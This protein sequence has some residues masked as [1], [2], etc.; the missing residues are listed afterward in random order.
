M[1]RNWRVFGFSL[2]LGQLLCVF[3]LL[4]RA[5]P[6]SDSLCQ[7]QTLSAGAGTCIESLEGQS[8]AVDPKSVFVGE[9]ISLCPPWLP[10]PAEIYLAFENSLGTQG[11]D[12]DSLVRKACTTFVGQVAA[13]SPNTNIDLAS[14]GNNT[15]MTFSGF[16]SMSDAGNVTALQDTAITQP[17][18]TGNRISSVLDTAIHYFGE[19]PITKTNR[20]VVMIISAGLGGPAG[21]KI[22]FN[23]GRVGLL[24]PVHIAYFKSSGTPTD[25]IKKYLGL[26]ADSTG[27]SFRISTSLAELTSVL[28]DSILPVLS[29]GGAYHNATIRNPVLSNQTTSKSGNGTVAPGSSLLRPLIQFPL[30]ALGIGD[31]Q[32]RIS[33]E[34][35]HKGDSVQSVE[36][37]FTLTRKV[38]ALTSGEQTA[39]D[40]VFSRS[41]TRLS[42][43]G[44]ADGADAL[45]ADG[46][47]YTSGVDSAR[48]LVYRQ[49]GTSEVQKDTVVIISLGGDSEAV[50]IMETG[51]ETDVYRGSVRIRYSADT[52]QKG[53]GTLEVRAADTLAATYINT[54]L[55]VAGGAP[56]DGCVDT[57]KV[58]MDQM[59][60]QDPA[61]SITF[62]NTRAFLA[63][64]S[65]R[66]ITWT[67]NDNV[68]I[69]GWEAFLATGSRNVWSSIGNGTG[70]PGEWQWNLPTIEQ[71]ACWIRMV[72]SDPAGNTA[73]DTSDE[74]FS[75]ITKPYFTSP[76]ADTA[77]TTRPYGYKVKWVIPAG[78]SGTIQIDPPSWM[79][80]KTV[81]TAW[82][83]T[84][85]T[86]GATDT[87][88]A[89]ISTTP[90]TY[91]ETLYVRIFIKQYVGIAAAPGQPLPVAMNA[92]MERLPGNALRAI[93]A[94]P[95][96]G[97]FALG[98]Y[99]ICGRAVWHG[100]KANAQAGFHSMRVDLRNG[101]RAGVYFLRLKS[102]ERN[103]VK[104]FIWTP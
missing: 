43:I 73:S 39:F 33:Y 31:N 87:L 28:V 10:V 38:D 72:V 12:P 32:I 45:L 4:V 62:P 92:V 23:S 78:L 89:I 61:V 70:N 59:D 98:V 26:I 25:T 35:V 90:S 7:V 37:N 15:N 86:P 57:I 52:P 69:A 49:P 11:Q 16:L 94:L 79:T 66:K 64:G 30:I 82:G 46:S 60:A 41:C 13:L 103:V 99:D 67:A 21:F 101:L 100:K 58:F 102:Q 8:I 44:F 24:P 97:E 14:Y 75:I 53:S 48:V 83:T 51:A 81:D 17:P 77:L 34:M 93:V 19:L 55:F 6:A 96:D 88:R 47:P 1:K 40:A 68:G 71:E 36:R 5:Q 84:P 54:G 50:E 65:A 9:D 2:I 3:P 22:W 29:P 42:A 74:P 63:K 27:G 56:Y 91:S 18:L 104:R 85:D 95:K 76:D 20:A 80:E